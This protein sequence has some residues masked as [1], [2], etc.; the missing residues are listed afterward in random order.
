MKPGSLIVILAGVGAFG[1]LLYSWSQGPISERNTEPYRNITPSQ[2]TAVAS[3]IVTMEEFSALAEGMTYDQAVRIIGEEGTILSTT[4][5][6]G[7]TTV[8]YQWMNQD[9]GNMNA[10]FQNNSMVSKAQFKL[11]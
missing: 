3:V 11:R 9:G 10:M 5:L 8:M 6:G 2:R 1:F 7:Y 4:T